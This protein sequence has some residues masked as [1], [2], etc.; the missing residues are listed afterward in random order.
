MKWAL[1]RSNIYES[2][3]FR[4]GSALLAAKSV[5]QYVSTPLSDHQWTVEGSQLFA[6]SLARIQFDAKAIATGEDRDRPGYIE[7]T[8]VEGKGRLCGIYKYK[9]IGYS[10]INIMAWIG[11]GTA[12][13][14]IWVL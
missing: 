5:A 4:L 6:T 2:I 8:P 3:K 10:N 14:A 12:A 9:S 1:A 13:A 7:V 11:I